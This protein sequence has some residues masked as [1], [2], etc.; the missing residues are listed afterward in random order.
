MDVRD[1]RKPFVMVSK[2]LAEDERLSST[3]KSVALSLASFV[4][5]C[6]TDRDAWPARKRI[7]KRAGVSNNT[8]SKSFNKLVEYGYLEIVERYKKGRD[9]NPTKERDTNVYVLKNV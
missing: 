1:E 5:N 9:G 8:L 3:D 7:A 2:A 4:N 6:K